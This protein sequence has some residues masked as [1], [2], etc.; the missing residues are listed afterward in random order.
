[1]G[2]EEEGN[3]VASIMNIQTASFEEKYLGLHVLEGRMKDGKFQPVKE[4]LKKLFSDYA[5]KYS[6]SGAKDVLIKSMVQAIPTYPMSVFQ[7]L[8][9]LC[10]DFMKMTRDFWWGDEDDKSKIH[11]MSWDKVTRRKGQGGMGLRD[12]H[13]FNQALLA[14]QAW[15]LIAFPDSLCARLLKAKYYPSGELTDTAF[16]TN[17]SPR[18]QGIMHGLELLKMALCGELEMEKR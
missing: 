8:E 17:P 5:E 2:S 1:L 12:L 18:W 7:F 11:W 15:R 10:E 14:R 3:V 6:S 4:K 9:G 13:L 16:I